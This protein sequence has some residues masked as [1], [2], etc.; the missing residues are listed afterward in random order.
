[1]NLDVQQKPFTGKNSQETKI[2]YAIGL[3]Q[4]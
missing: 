1:M 3:A 4:R 2:S